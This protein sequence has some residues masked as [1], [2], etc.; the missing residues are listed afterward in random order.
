[1]SK[2]N[3]I[4]IIGM[5]ILLF[6]GYISACI[7]IIAL[8][9]TKPTVIVSE[10]TSNQ[11][12]ITPI[13]IITPTEITKRFYK[14]TQVIDGDTIQLDDYGKSLKIRLI[15]IDAPEKDQKECFSIEAMNKLKEM[16][17]ENLVYLEL[18]ESQG[19]F[20]KY[21]RTLAYVYPESNPTKNLNLELI[22]EGYAHEY[23][24]NKP[25]KYQ[26]EFKQAE[27]EA[28]LNKKGLWSDSACPTIIVQNTPIPTPTPIITSNAKISPTITK[29]PII[30]VSYT[31]IPIKS[32]ISSP[33]PTLSTGYGCDCNKGCKRITTC[34]EAYY[35]LTTCGCSVRDNDKDGIP[36]EDG[37]C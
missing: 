16:I 6:C 37:P 29:A 28:M 27:K 14:V 10:E 34:E 15:G 1:M 25:Y 5:V 2:S 23:T 36:C 24:Y 8:S 26:E 30:F 12:E 13:K 22:S 31:P 3:V 20:D 33:A 9:N 19:E 4:L 35:Q 17:G 32:S 21:Q 11:V 7:V 18:D